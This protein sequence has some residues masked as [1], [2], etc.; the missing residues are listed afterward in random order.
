[1]K[2]ISQVTY[3]LLLLGLLGCQSTTQTFQPQIPPFINE[4]SSFKV[5][6]VESKDEIFALNKEIKKN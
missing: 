2:T 5:L 4:P 1:M 6:E 3:L